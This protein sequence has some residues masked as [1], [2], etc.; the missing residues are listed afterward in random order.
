MSSLADET[1][2]MDAVDQAALV[3]K[4]EVTPLELLEAAIERMEATDPQ[5]HALTITWFDHAREVA[6]GELPDGPFR[7][8]PV[9]AQ[10]PLHEL[11]RPD[12][13]Q[14][15]QRAEGGG[16]RRHARHDARRQVPGGRARDRRAHEQP[17]AGQPA[18]DAAAGVGPDAQPVGPRPHAR[19]VERRV[20]P[21]RSPPGWCRSPTRPTAAAASASRRRRAGWSGS[22][23]A[24]AGSPS[25]R[26]APRS[27]SASSTA[28]AAPCATRP[29]S[30]T[31][32]AVRASATPS[33]PPRP[34]RPYADEVGADPGRLRIGLL[35]VHPLGGVLHDDC[36]AAARSAAIDAGGPRPRRRAGVAGGA[37]RRVADAA[38]HGAVGDADGD[39]RQRRSARRSGGRSPPTTSS[40]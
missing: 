25:A 15:Q 30:S 34:A 2:W 5:L 21:R 7:G 4:G 13:V 16:D 40:R 38:V 23:R 6:A 35:D 17:G 11:R 27:V 9:P 31:P 29:C 36:V 33:S 22:S 8:V 28:S 20:L 3:A 12:A 32:S 10:G 26:S 19:R 1:R 18:D 37:R 39:G 24:R 14:R